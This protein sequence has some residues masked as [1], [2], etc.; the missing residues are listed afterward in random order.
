MGASQLAMV[1]AALVTT[2]AAFIKSNPAKSD[3][4]KKE[5]DAKPTTEMASSTAAGGAP[6]GSRSR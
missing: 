5:A 6:G 4:W 3:E 2:R 1:T